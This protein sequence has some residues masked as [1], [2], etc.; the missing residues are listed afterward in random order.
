MNNYL[1]KL[2]YKINCLPESYVNDMLKDYQS[3]FYE[4]GE[5]G[6]T[7]EE[8]ILELGDVEY[9]GNNIIAEYFIENSN[10]INGIKT[11]SRALKAVGTLGIGVLNLIIM[12]PIIFSVLIALASLYFVGTVF[13]MSPV[14]LI[15]H[16]ISPEL[17]ISFG[18]DIAIIKFIITSAMLMFGFIILRTSNR[19]RPKILRWSFLYI[20]KSIKFK[21]IKF[22]GII[23]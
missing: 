15:I 8:M 22:E 14:F 17:P 18:T 19:I 9:I 1:D 11:Y 4:G 13:V 12:I 2:K 20:I 7:E 21:A 16:V 6:K 3:Y 23:G 10:K 5:S